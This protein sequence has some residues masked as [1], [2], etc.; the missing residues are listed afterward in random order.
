MCVAI[1]ELLELDVQPF[2][3]PILDTSPN[4]TVSVGG[5]LL[6]VRFRGAPDGGY[7][8]EIGNGVSGDRDG[9]NHGHHIHTQIGA[10]SVLRSPLA[11]R[12]LLV[13]AP[14]TL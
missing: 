6:S 12:R 14:E 10:Q 1:H 5:W 13:S 11:L 4:S 9:T 7:D 8:K 2:T 3:M